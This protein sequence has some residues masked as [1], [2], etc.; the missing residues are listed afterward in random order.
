MV[1]VAVGSGIRHAIL[2]IESGGNNGFQH[3]RML[4]WAGS[5]PLHPIMLKPKT[6]LRLVLFALIGAALVYAVWRFTRPQPPEVEL[7]TIAHGPVEATVV[8][9]R[10]GTVK[11]CRR[12]KFPWRAARS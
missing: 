10:A 8:N 2:E 5:L 12:A 7:A 11:A 1:N 4:H 9:T 6:W 3:G